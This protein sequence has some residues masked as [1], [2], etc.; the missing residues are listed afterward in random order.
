MFWNRRQE[1]L[2]YTAIQHFFGTAA[3][4][5]IFLELQQESAAEQMLTSRSQRQ[6]GE[7]NRGSRLASARQGRTLRNDAKNRLIRLA[8]R[9]VE[10]VAV[11]KL[12][13]PPGCETGGA[14]RAVGLGTGTK[15]AGARAAD[16]TAA[17]SASWV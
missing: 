17:W 15:T 6:S 5:G 16:L 2:A 1:G 3:R 9:D 12:A 4:L 13:Q 14:R 7:T 11:D 8:M 10:L